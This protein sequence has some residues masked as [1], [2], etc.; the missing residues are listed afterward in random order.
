MM[1]KTSATIGIAAVIIMSANN[2]E[3]RL[4]NGYSIGAN[5]GILV[6]QNRLG[7]TKIDGFRLKFKGKSST[8][9]YLGIQGDF[10]MS[11]P[12]DLY[13]ALGI[14]L[15]FP[16]TGSKSKTTSF[17]NVNAILLTTGFTLDSITLKYKV[18]QGI[19]SDFTFSGGYNFCNQTVLYALVGF[20]LSSKNHK[21]KFIET[22]TDF[23]PT[24]TVTT[25][26][27]GRKQKT[28]PVFGAGFKTK[29]APKITTGLE[30]KYSYKNNGIKYKID[31]PVISGKI[32]SH[33][34]AVLARASF[35]MYSL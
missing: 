33:D 12:N 22:I 10:E 20:R 6:D 32:K 17:S 21:L 35:H 15:N 25:Y 34:H 16:T 26:T 19:N 5:G 29:V 24:T 27:R 30:Y 4:F 2:A 11:R 28:T 1:I 8:M 7:V 18:K 23:T 9:G 14:S 13:G 3:A 31:G